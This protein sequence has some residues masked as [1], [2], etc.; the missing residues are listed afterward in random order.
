MHLLQRARGRLRQRGV[1]MV[2]GVVVMPVLCMFFVLNTFLMGTLDQK[3]YV[4][5]KAR[6]TAMFFA[7]NS[8]DQS[9]GNAGPRAGMDPGLQGVPSGQGT[10]SQV[11]GQS[12][13]TSSSLVGGSQSTYTSQ[14]TYFGHTAPHI[15]SVSNVLCNEKLWGGDSGISS[16]L[17]FFDL[18]LNMLTGMFGFR[19]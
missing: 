1:A 2:E 6:E 19:M 17:G 5:R 16:L 8:C 3:I 4:Q 18:G 7:S 10:G 14:F 12:G 15:Q 13:M 11:Q 9:E